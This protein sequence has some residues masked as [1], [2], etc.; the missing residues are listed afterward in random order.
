MT[1]AATVANAA[2]RDYKGIQ[3]PVPGDYVLDKAHT[4]IEFVARHLMISKVRGRFTEFDGSIQIAEDPEQSKLEVSIVASS[5][6]TSEP[7][8]DAHL[9]SA[10][11]LDTD[12]YPELTFQSTKIEHVNDTEWKLTGD[13]SIRGVTKPITLEVEFLGV[14]VSPWGTRPFGFEATAEI[15]REDWGLTWN[16]ALE[17]GGVVIGKKVRIEINAEL[18]PRQ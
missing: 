18:L 2:T 9:R 1:E 7:T 6:D 8:R 17:T 11:F 4:T 13:L 5:I 12:K 16:Q 14:T 3:T 10:D 15:D